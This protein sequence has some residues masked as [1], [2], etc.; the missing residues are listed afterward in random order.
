MYKF[1]S[2]IL[3]ALLF[4]AC[5]SEDDPS[6]GASP[7][8]GGD[9]ISFGVP[10]VKT[11][12]SVT[13]AVLMNAIEPHTVFGV[14]GYCVPYQLAADR[15]DWQGGN[16]DWLTKKSLAHA[17]VMYR[18]PVF[19]DG[20][21]CVYSSDGTRFN[22]PKHWYTPQE[23]GLTNT[24]RFLY[25]FI[26]YH[27]YGLLAEGGGF[28]FS[29]A[30]DATRGIP[31]LTYTMPYRSGGS[32]SDVLD[33]DAAEDAM[34]AASFDHSSTQGAVQFEFRHLLTG[35]RLQ[36]NNYNAADAANPR[37][38]TVTVH[39]LSVEGDF[40]R[41]AEIDFPPADPAMSVTGETFSGTFRFVGAA[42]G[43]QVAPNSARV[44]GAT[45]DAPQGT[46]LLLLPKFDAAAGGA[47]SSIPY[48]GT[49]K[50]IEIEYSYEGKDR[51]TRR[52]ENFS[53]GRVPEQGTCYT[54]NLNFIGD[55]LL[56][57]FTAD[58]IEY[59]ESGSDNDIIIN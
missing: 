35:L 12:R 53:L 46:V 7:D 21:K 43:L 31:K 36:I 30:D 45:T 59:W 25:S 51:V 41:T 34:I 11:D 23:T 29:P 10:A 3:S 44:V 57:M 42:D 54:I 33:A 26:A 37:A 13:R 58:A 50:T 16:S 9:A 22:R 32:L 38:N 28:S 49:R 1:L 55:Q 47:T 4:V 52:I 6:G 39:S 40:Y 20:V 27:P 24:G 2:C 14:L 17:D 8:Y 48:L 5:S 18:E 19:Y 15:P 56:L